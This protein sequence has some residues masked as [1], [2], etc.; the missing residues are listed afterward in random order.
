MLFHRSTVTPLFTIF[1][2]SAIAEA[3]WKTLLACHVMDFYSALEILFKQM[4]D[5]IQCLHNTV[6]E[7]SMSLELPRTRWTLLSNKQSSEKE[8]TRQS[9]NNIITNYWRTDNISMT[10][11][12]DSTTRKTS[13]QNKLHIIGIQE[14]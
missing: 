4:D 10:S 13:H 3:S 8:R 12:T 2:M 9:S 11:K 14:E 1:I 5:K 6:R 7:L